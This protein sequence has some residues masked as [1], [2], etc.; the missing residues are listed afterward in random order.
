M[1]GIQNYVAVGGSP[2]LE[3]LEQQLR[4]ELQVILEQERMFWW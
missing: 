2:Y 3:T 1:N 4:M